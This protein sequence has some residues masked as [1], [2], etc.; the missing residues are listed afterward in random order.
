MLFYLSLLNLLSDWTGL[1]SERGA[2]FDARVPGVQS[3][4]RCDTAGEIGD[5]VLDCE[6][7]LY[8][9]GALFRG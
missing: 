3:R 9:H 4:G 1:R 2:H 7:Y 8:D 6:Q 5:G